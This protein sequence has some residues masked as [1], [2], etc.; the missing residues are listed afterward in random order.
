MQHLPR[1]IVA[2]IYGL[3]G[4]DTWGQKQAT[5]VFVSIL[6]AFNFK[7]DGPIRLL[8]VSYDRYERMYDKSNVNWKFTDE[9]VGAR[10][11]LE[12]NPYEASRAEWLMQH[13]YVA[14]QPWN[15]REMLAEATKQAEAAEQAEFEAAQKRRLAA[16]LPKPED[17]AEAIAVTYPGGT[18][19][20]RHAQGSNQKSHR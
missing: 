12:D 19:S 4:L 2:V 14:E 3:K 7:E 15:A 16:S 20:S 13:P 8:K 11:F 1:S 17:Y 5:Q 9:S 6:D 18:V 10:K